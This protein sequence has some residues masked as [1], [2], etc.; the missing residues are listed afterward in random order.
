MLGAHVLAHWS[1]TQSS[2]ALSS[3]EAELNSALKGGCELLGMSEL[4]KEWGRTVTLKL[5]GDSSA[6]KGVLHREGSGRLKHVEVKQLWL[7]QA[8]GE[9]AILFEK[10]PRSRNAADTLTKH[11]CQNDLH[12]FQRLGFHACSEGGH[13]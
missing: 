7:Q 1:R 10:I 3:C 8:V 6:C 12:H 4:L 9:R 2:V 5:K 11:W 13:C